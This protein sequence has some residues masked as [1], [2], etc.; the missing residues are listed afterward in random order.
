MKCPHCITSVHE[1]WTT[2]ANLGGD[3]DGDWHVL[4]MTSPEC[5]RIVVR[6]DLYRPG[7][8]P[9]VQMIVYPR[10]SIRPPLSPD[11]PSPYRDDY[12]DSCAVLPDSP[13]ASAALS[14]RSLQQLLREKAEVEPGNLSG[15]IDQAM[16]QLPSQLAGAIDAI[17]NVGNFAAHPLKDTNTGEIVDVE[18]GEAEW[19]LDVLE[20][21]FDFYFAL[22]E[23]LSRK[24]A[25]L[26]EKLE[27]AGKPPMK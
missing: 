10:S 1:S 21:L 12:R 6:L 19:L 15:E 4:H 27:A 16:E 25:K 13:K 3:A 17:R 22:P 14:R 7:E 9:Q 18:P 26:N 20:Q 8:T 11:V 23:I 24:R 5:R 2:A